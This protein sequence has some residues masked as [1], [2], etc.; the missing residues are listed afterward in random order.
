MSALWSL[1]TVCAMS[2]CRI[3]SI[4]SPVDA[5]P[6]PGALT[7]PRS[8]KSSVT[9][10]AR[11]IWPR[12][13]FGLGTSSG[14]WRRWADGQRRGACGLCVACSVWRASFGLISVAC[15]VWRI[16]VAYSV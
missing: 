6:A 8:S 10:S 7:L 3:I 11:L 4:L 15:S 1:T 2:R 14:L 13:P 5:E 12:S 9:H 16:C